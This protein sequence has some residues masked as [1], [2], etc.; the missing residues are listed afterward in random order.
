DKALAEQLRILKP[1]GIMATLDTTPPPDNLLKPFIL[2]HLKYIIPT[3]GR[4]IVDDPDAYTYL[5]SSTLR[6]KTPQDFQHLME[7][8]GFQQVR[9]QRFMFGTMAVHWGRKL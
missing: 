2:I 7:K 5:P 8:A 9:Y 1:G 4:I 3:I 6:Y